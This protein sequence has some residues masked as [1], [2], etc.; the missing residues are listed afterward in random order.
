MEQIDVAALNTILAQVHLVDV[1]EP[2]E[3]SNGHVPGA[4]SMPLATVPVRI[5]ELPKSTPIHLICQAGGRSMQAAAYLEN[6][7]YTV[8]NVAGGTGSWIA[9]GFPV[10]R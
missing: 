8:V 7:G 3:Y 6:A 5:N 1:R 4:I 9:S 10:E 2:F